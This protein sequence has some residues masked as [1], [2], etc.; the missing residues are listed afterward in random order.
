MILN[1]INVS[2]NKLQIPDVSFNALLKNKKEIFNINECLYEIAYR[3]GY[4]KI[5]NI[6]F[7]NDM[8]NKQCRNKSFIEYL[9]ENEEYKENININVKDANDEYPM[10]T[11]L[12]SSQNE[13]LKYLIE[14]AGG[15]Y[16]I[17]NNS[18][19]SLLIIALQRKNNDIVKYLFEKPNLKIDEKDPNGKSVFLNA[20]SQNNQDIIELLFDYNT[21]NKIPININEKDASG[22]CPITRAINKNNF[23]RV[24]LLMEYA[25]SNKIDMNLTDINGYSLLRLCYIQ[26]FINIFKYLIEY[27]D[28]NKKDKFGKSII[29]YAVDENDIETVKYLI[30]CGADLNIR[31]FSNNSIIDYAMF[32]NNIDLLNILIQKDNLSLNKFNSKNET[33]II[34]L[35]KNKNSTTEKKIKIIINYINRGCDINKLNNYVVNKLSSLIHA[36]ENDE[37]SLTEL[38]INMGANINIKNGKGYTYLRYGI[39]K[40]MGNYSNFYSDGITKLLFKNELY[41]I[42]NDDKLFFSEFSEFSEISEKKLNEIKRLISSIVDINIVDYNGNTLLHVAVSKKKTRI[43]KTFN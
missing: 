27:L 38:L 7:K 1:L 32:N 35:I 19:T 24:I 2:K 12:Y 13:I 41:N 16:N 18:G 22:N 6:L 37:L 25:I 40:V 31:D 26:G 4:N 20:M 23:D 30:N 15:D 43:S 5:L 8:S 28:I 3:K 21:A 39:N 9:I 14:H 17:K 33:P 10:I 11:A 42:Y 29:F 34:S 36:I